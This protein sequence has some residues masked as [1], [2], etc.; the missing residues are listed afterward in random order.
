M[1]SAPMDRLWPKVVKEEMTDFKDL[2]DKELKQ[3]LSDSEVLKYKEIIEILKNKKLLKAEIIE[4]LSLYLFWRLEV[5]SFLITVYIF[6][7]IVN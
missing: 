5:S 4:L 1:V 7:Y 6:F 3:T 2:Q